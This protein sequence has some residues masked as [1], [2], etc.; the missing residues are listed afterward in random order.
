MDIPNIHVVR[1]PKF[2]TFIRCRSD[3]VFKDFIKKPET[4]FQED[5]ACVTFIMVLRHFYYD[6]ASK[7]KH[8][9]RVLSL[10]YLTNFEPGRQFRIL[11][12]NYHQ[13][14]KEN[15]ALS[16]LLAARPG[17]PLGSMER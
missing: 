1:T 15:D 5:V 7:I 11:E 12:Y 6:F 8:Q 2:E 3:P 17:L 10:Q 16:A 14:G 9:G 13:G 4:V